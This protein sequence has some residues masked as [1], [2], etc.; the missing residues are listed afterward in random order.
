MRNKLLKIFILSVLLQWG[1]AY[2]DCIKTIVMIRHGEI[3]LLA[4]HGQLDCQGLNR[5][6]ALRTV[7]DAEYG[8]PAAIYAAD[9][10]VTATSSSSDPTCYNYVRPLATIE[11]TAIYY[12]MGVITTYSEG[13]CRR[14][15]WP[16]RSYGE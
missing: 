3:N 13:A 1:S 8:Q 4:P 11:P 14:S 10:T 2:A 7:L 16:I 9:P 5:A 6:L 15:Y 12:D